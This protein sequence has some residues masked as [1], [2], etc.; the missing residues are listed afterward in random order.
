[1]FTE[2]SLLKLTGPHEVIRRGG[3]TTRSRPFFFPCLKIE[4]GEEPS[5][6]GETFIQ[7]KKIPLP[8]GGRKGIT[9]TGSFGQGK[10]VIRLS[11]SAGGEGG[12]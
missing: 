12:I 3:D 9:W 5:P 6:R 8:G 10:N 2:E 4:K 7:K 11:S 1:M